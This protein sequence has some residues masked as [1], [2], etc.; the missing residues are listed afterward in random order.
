MNRENGK[1]RCGQVMV[2]GCMCGGDCPFASCVSAFGS[3][4]EPLYRFGQLLGQ[5]EGKED[6]GK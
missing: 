3:T 1:S 4:E 2:L 6:D 5:A